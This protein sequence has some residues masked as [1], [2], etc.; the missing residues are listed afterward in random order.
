MSSLCRDFGEPTEQVRIDATSRERRM[1]VTLGT[2]GSR[3]EAPPMP[4]A[5]VA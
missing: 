5:T 3:T 1:S 4:A 2:R